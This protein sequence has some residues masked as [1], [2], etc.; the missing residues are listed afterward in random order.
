MF[1]GKDITT[2][3]ELVER[4]SIAEYLQHEQTDV[5]VT[6]GAGNIDVVCADVAKVITAKIE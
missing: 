1:I 2:E 4:D 5:T 6:F 3:W